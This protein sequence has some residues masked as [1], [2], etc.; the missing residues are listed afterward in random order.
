MGEPRDQDPNRHGR[1]Q[2]AAALEGF[3]IIGGQR[4]VISMTEYL[5][6]DSTLETVQVLL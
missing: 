3:L 1:G 6:W 2:D 4:G 5:E